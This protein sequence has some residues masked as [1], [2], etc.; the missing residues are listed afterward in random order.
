M[1]S[2]SV[3]Q[4][5]FLFLLIAV[6]LAFIGILLP[7]YGAI[8]WAVVLAVMFAP[9][10]RR[11]ALRTGGQGN[12]SALLTLLICLVVA[13]LP[14]IV[15]TTMVVDEG[16]TLYQRIKS[17]ELDVGAYITQAKSMLPGAVQAQLERFGFGDLESLKQKI[18]NGAMA[19]SQFLATQ[20]FAIGQG[21]FEF[22]VSFG[23]MLYLL[24]FLLRDGEQILRDMRSLIPL[25]DTQKRRLQIKFVRVVRAT[26]KGN[27]VVAA[28]QGTLGG[29]TLWLLGIPGA[30][31]WGVLMGFLSLLPAAGAGIVW[32]PVAAYLL[33]AGQIWQGVVLVLVGVFVIG[34]VD[35]ILRPL[36]VGRDT[37]MPDYLILISTLG[38]LSLLG[39]NGFVIGPLIAALFLAC[40]NLSS[41]SRRRR[42]PRRIVM[43]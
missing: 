27:L 24:F 21:T 38:G 20:V 11:L 5:T 33:L 25:S 8:F 37:R 36:L 4:K 18:S 12:R 22:V 15:I 17:G 43:K 6:T 1:H 42:E 19:G 31:L 10:Q 41:G 30:L 26:V 16:A 13:I 7:F 40:W 3:E 9:L 32:V 35:N 23:I 39:L 14:V 2:P 29:V 28:V 34:L